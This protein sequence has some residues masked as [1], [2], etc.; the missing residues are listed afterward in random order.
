MRRRGTPYV[1]VQGDDARWAVPAAQAL[2]VRDAGVLPLPAPRGGV[3]GL[4]TGDGEPVPVS[5][6]LAGAGGTV[7]LVADGLR[8]CAL[9]VTTVLAVTP[10]PDPAP[11]P[12]GQARPYVRGTT[13]HDEETA[14][15]LDVP[16]LL[17]DIHGVRR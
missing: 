17:D 12:A 4:H 13:T 1:V 3:V 10:L 14:L 7:L 15:V 6:A 9:L 5:T 2:A 11:A 8:R 16:L